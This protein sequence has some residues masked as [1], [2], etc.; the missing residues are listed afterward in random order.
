MQNMLG[1]MSQ[2]FDALPY[3][4]FAKNNAHQWIYGNKAFEALIGTSDFIGKDD[5]AFFPPS[6]VKAFRTDACSQARKA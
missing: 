2:I 3:P 6:Q 5:R 1:Y 4:V